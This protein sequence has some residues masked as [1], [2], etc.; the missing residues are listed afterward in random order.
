MKRFRAMVVS[1]GYTEVEAETE[2]EALEKCEDMIT[3]GRQAFDWSQ[4]DNAQ[5][6]E[7]IDN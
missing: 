3:Q 2:S 4:P 5:I 6:I 1:Y 7:E